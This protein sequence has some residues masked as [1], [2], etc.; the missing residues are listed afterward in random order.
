MKDTIMRQSSSC[1]LGKEIKWSEN[2]DSPKKL[3]INVHGSFIQNSQ[4]LQT[5]KQYVSRWIV[6]LCYGH[7]IQCCLAMKRSELEMEA[8]T[9]W[10]AMEFCVVKKKKTE[11][12][13]FHTVWFHVWNFKKL[14]HFRNEEQICYC[15]GLMTGGGWVWRMWVWL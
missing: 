1:T 7:T 4:Q 10:I 14:Y 11:S 12:K 6:Q 15:Q 9:G 8:T 13:M 3:Y 5:S 2:L